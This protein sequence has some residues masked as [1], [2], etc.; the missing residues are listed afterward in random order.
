MSSVGYYLLSLLIILKL[1]YL[2]NDVHHMN[3]QILVYFLLMYADDLVLFSETLNGL[4]Q[5]WD[6]LFE[7]S[8]KWGMEVN[9]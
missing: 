8:Q 4:Q 6:C 9:I 1:I 2:L 5:L 3:V 7:Y